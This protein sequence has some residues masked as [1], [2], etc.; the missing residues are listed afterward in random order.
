[1]TETRA[2]ADRPPIVAHTLCMFANDVFISYT[3]EDDSEEAGIRWV[4]RF[5]AELKHRLAKVSGHSINSWR[6]DKL[7]G[8]DRF[9]PEIEQQLLGS[10]VLVSV[11]TPSYFRSEWCTNER[12]TFIRRAEAGPG[13]NVGNKARVVKAA[14]TRVPQPVWGTNQSDSAGPS[15]LDC[16]GGLVISSRIWSARTSRVRS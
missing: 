13:L 9:G 3:H 16:V 12:T 8:A 15:S 14:K 1:V 7:S 10:A 5:E 11:V 2:Y 6:D 4:A